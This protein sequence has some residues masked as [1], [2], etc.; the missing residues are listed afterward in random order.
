M[1][2]PRS[3]GRLVLTHSDIYAFLACRRWFDWSYN[4]DFRL[5]EVEWGARALG[6]RVHA[7]VQ[8]FWHGEDVVAAH[9]ELAKTAV[10]TVEA[11]PSSPPFAVEELYRDIILGRNACR[12]FREWVEREGPYDGFTVIGVEQVLEAEVGEGVLLRG[13]ADLLLQRD[14]DGAIFVDDLKTSS[15]YRAGVREGLER[16]YQH[17]VYLMLATAQ[18]PETLIGG[19]YY[20]VLY[21]YRNPAASTGPLVERWM[22]PAS[23]RTLVV[24]QAQINFIVNE[25]TRMMAMSDE[26]GS[27]VAYPTPQDRCRWCDFAKPCE[28]Y[29]DAPLAARAMLDSEYQRGGRHDR[30]AREE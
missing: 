15:R 14:S 26:L 11:D 30:Y 5:P 2:A 25:I 22:V 1:N 3:H 16:S 9:E 23:R 27:V 21:K 20:T 24:R 29:D 13:R 7:A 10:E 19:A 18:N 12:A 28:L 17:S 6:S 8:R 4:R